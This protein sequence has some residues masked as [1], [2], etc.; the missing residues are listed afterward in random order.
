MKRIHFEVGESAVT[1][2]S[3]ERY[4]KAAKDAIFEARQILHSKIAE[5]PF[6]GTTY[7]PYEVRPDDHPMIRNMCRCSLLAEVGP[8]A[9]VAGAVAYHAVERMAESGA[10]FAIVENGGDI[11]LKIDRPVTVGLFTGDD[12]LKDIAM[13]VQPR[14][15]IFG[16]CS[17]SG[18]IG[19]SVSFGSSDICT[20]ISDDVMLADGCATAFGNLVKDGNDISDASERICSI[21]GVDGCI[22]SIDG[23]V[24]LQGDVPELVRRKVNA[25]NASRILL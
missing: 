19:P 7:F 25:E 8:M 1:I 5:D 20:V 16:V 14:D 13:K 22:A 23:K 15:G 10:E 6:F 2:L 9:C 11:A 12:R 24:S 3:D 17:S 21:E 4:H 18:R